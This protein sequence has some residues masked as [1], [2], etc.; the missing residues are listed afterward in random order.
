M[1]QT[2]K[3]IWYLSNMLRGS[4]KKHIQDKSSESYS[5]RVGYKERYMAKVDKKH[6]ENDKAYCQGMEDV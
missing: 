2:E 3:W 5:E 1:T 6:F 4:L